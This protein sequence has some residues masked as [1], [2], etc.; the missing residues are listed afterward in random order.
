MEPDVRDQIVRELYKLQE[1][2]G[3]TMSTLIAWTGISRSKFHQWGKLTG[4]PR[5]E[6]KA[7][8]RSHYLL[9]EER[10]AILA[11]ARSHAEN[12][13][14][15]LTYMMID[16]DVASVSPSSTYRVLL[17]GGLLHRWNR[18]E[19]GKGRGFHQPG[20]P[21]EH[22]HTDIKYVNFQGTFL[23]LI[24]VI[25]GY[26][27]FI[28]HHELRASMEEYDVQIT[29]E[30]ALENYPQERPRLITDN[31]SQF[32]AKDFA[33]FLRLKGL[34]H[35]RTSIGYPQSNGKIE[36]YHAT[37]NSECLRRKSMI[38]LDDARRQI[39]Q[40][41]EFYN[42][43]RLHSALFYLTPEDVLFGRMRE[44]IAEREDKLFRAAE[45]RRTRF[46]DQSNPARANDRAEGD[47]R[48]N[49]RSEGVSASIA[50]LA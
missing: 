22:W 11:Y 37:I 38:T 4:S 29:L 14:R 49:S 39:A 45:R 5:R 32:I 18:S 30:R 16:E 42:T 17:E 41:V 28:V 48:E 50:E 33:Q 20:R 27:R 43:K 46:A 36:R 2:T 3:L 19:S 44:R 8:P 40:Y 7:I 26:S 15:R 24:S 13:Y 12:G 1:R 9:P 25:D 10:E 35:V 21:H 31:G 34:Q 23:F 47:R 6:R